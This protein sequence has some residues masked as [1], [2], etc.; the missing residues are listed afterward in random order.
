[1]ALFS[2]TLTDNPYRKLGKMLE[3]EKILAK[4]HFKEAFERAKKENRAI[5]EIIFEKENLPPDKLLS[6][7]THYFRLPAVALREKVI[8]PT[9]LNLI[10]KEV[11]EHGAVIIFKKIKKIIYVATTNPENKLVFNFIKKK[12]G[13]EPK[14]FL[15]TPKDLQTGLKKYKTEIATEFEK[16]IQESTNQ[17]LSLHENPE[18]LAQ[19]VPTIKMVDTIIEQALL[20]NA[21]DIHIEPI[22]EKI[23]VRYRIDGIMQK[24]VALPKEI[25]PP[26][27]TRI[28]ILAN[29]KIDEHRLPQDGRFK[30]N[31]SD[32]PVAIRV[33][34]MPT[35]NGA[36]VVL[37]LLDVKEKQFSL[38]RL[39]LNPRD[40][41]SVKKEISK[42]HGLILV[43]GPTGS[44][45]TT[46]L[47]AILRLLNK[48]GVN[49]CTIEDPIE[50]G[51]EGINQTQINPAAGLTFASGLRSL[52]R[53][54]PDIIMVGEI[55]DLET[56][57]MA[58]NAAMTGH[59]VLSTLHTNSAFL[60]I[61]RLIEMGVKPF[62]AASVINVVMGQRLV[63]RIC[64]YCK[65]QRGST[66]KILAQYQG[67][68]D[69]E[70]TLTKLKRLNLLPLV[71]FNSLSEIKFTHG[72]G[73][74]KCHGT[75]YL[76]RVGIYE[77]LKND[78]N[79]YQTILKD[80]T[81]AAIKNE[82]LKHD[83]L[84]MTEDGLLKIFKGLTTFEEVLRVTKE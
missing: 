56:A 8:D 25:L 70:N 14:I 20:Q 7:F 75:G 47:Y 50:Y 73:C 74:P 18:K 45:K 58:V 44:G 34:V 30:F 22:L 33:S 13:F 49:I 32:R 57:E 17:V 4:D 68:F 38:R 9:V 11:A 24:I 15:T 35:M 64:R 71:G 54:D 59:L 53:Q 61:Q 42:P 63:R 69:L 36:K 3:K 51:L 72:K 1:M 41:V 16:I 62:L 12:T 83:L 78:Q 23:S 40:L 65:S 19:I 55:R 82:A 43:T 79:L 27:V 67:Y 26:V 84:T 31:F 81:A 39:G 60:V 5:T 28:K 46:T 48:E 10:P 76:G 77:I 29:L 80:P 21:S 66:E 6:V 37:R 2:F 52:I